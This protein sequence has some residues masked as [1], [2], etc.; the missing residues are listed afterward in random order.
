MA[1]LPQPARQRRRCSPSRAA[2]A[3]RAFGNAITFGQD[4]SEEDMHRLLDDLSAAIPP[5]A[6]TMCAAVRGVSSR[7]WCRRGACSYASAMK[8]PT[9]VPYA[10]WAARLTSG[11]RAP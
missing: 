7:C 8:P 11:V 9:T 10:T 6:I 5:P 1:E 3:T 4:L 2:R